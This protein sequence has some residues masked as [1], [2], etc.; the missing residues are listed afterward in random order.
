M[1]AVRGEVFE[2]C[3]ES[4]ITGLVGTISFMVIDNDGGT[5]IAAS[6]VGIIETPAGSGIY[7][8]ERI[9]PNDLG[10]Y[11]MVWSTDGSYDNFSVSIDDLVVLSDTA[12]T[13]PLQPIA[14]ELHGL[15][16]AWT[17]SEEVALCC[18]AEV[19]SD[20]DVFDNAVVAASQILYELSGR[21]FTGL[22]SKTVRPCRTTC[23]CDWQMLSRGYVIWHGDLWGCDEV[24]C[25]CSPLSKVELS[26]YPVQEILEVKI[27]GIVLSP[28]E[29]RVDS[30]RF[31]IRKNDGNWP[32][33]QNL[34]LDDTEAGT[35]SVEYSY[36]FAPPL[37]GVAAAGELACE[38]YKACDDSLQLECILPQGITRIVRQGITI[39]RSAFVAWGRLMG[40]WRTGL[41][42]VDLF[43]N[44]YNPSGARRRPIFMT[45]GK[46]AFPLNT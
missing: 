28:D 13:T 39:E 18:S 17:T 20:V 1:E 14:G 33:C 16:S 19:G 5:A 44:A 27:D 35:W 45:P 37:A 10:Q 7:C 26:G 22:C 21:K 12:G 9:A 41:P 30:K 43:L 46:R 15:C 23:G 29:Y 36:G 38:I 40:I 24:A 8:V 25:G 2:A 32:G 6:T 4:G 34:S 42:L 31:L 11:S 3:F